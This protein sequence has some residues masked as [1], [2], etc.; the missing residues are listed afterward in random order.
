MRISHASG[1]AT[2]DELEHAYRSHSEAKNAMKSDERDLE[3]KVKNGEPLTYEEHKAR[4]VN[5]SV[6]E[7]R[8][9]DGKIVDMKMTRF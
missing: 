6:L 5:V 8:G 2:K 7:R 9:P 1:D 3:R 4:S